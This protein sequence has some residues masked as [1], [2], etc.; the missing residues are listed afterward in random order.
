MLTR[1]GG[2]KLSGPIVV[3][4]YWCIYTCSPAVE[5]EYRPGLPDIRTVGEGMEL[6][7]E[8]YAAYKNG[9]REDPV[10]YVEGE[11][12]EYCHVLSYFL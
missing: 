9:F 8:E 11:D 2:P 6:L 3:I 1:T 5:H 10:G 4:V 12:I 7:M